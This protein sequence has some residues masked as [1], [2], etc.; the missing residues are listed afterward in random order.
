LRIVTHFA[1]RDALHKLA[2]IAEPLE[3]TN[4]GDA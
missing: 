4:T 1:G 3:G 2:D